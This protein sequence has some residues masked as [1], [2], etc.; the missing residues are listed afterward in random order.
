MTKGAKLAVLVIVAVIAF[1]GALLV[2][3]GG[4]SSDNGTV[5]AGS[6]SGSTAPRG[7][8][9]GVT[10]GAA[11]T[12]SCPANGASDP[13]YEVTVEGATKVESKA[14]VIAVTRDGKPVTGATVCI[15]AAMSG[16]SHEGVSTKAVDLSG[17]RYELDGMSFGMQ[18]AWAGT[19]TIA[20]SGR[21]AASVPL[22]FDVQ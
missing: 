19:V 12:G 8:T 10:S 15:E 11:T 22:T 14:L 3:R 17:G 20:E 21:Q 13:A 16:M 5:A 4:G 7:I 9:T 6:Q 2:F 1:G 18:G